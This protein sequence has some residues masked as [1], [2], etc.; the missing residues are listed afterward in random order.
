MRRRKI[1]SLPASVSK[2]QRPSFFTMGTGN[3]QKF[4]P[5]SSTHFVSDSWTSR[6]VALRAVVNALNSLVAWT[7]SGFCRSAAAGPKMARRASPL[8]A[9]VARTS[10]ETASS[11]VAKA[12]P[13]SAALVAMG[14]LRA[15]ATTRLPSLTTRKYLFSPAQSGTFP[16]SLHIRQRKG[17]GSGMDFI[18]DLL[19]RRPSAATATESAAAA[20]ERCGCRHWRTRGCYNCARSSRCSP[21]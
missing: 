1:S 12:L 8:C 11:G 17:F 9:V 21:R 7:R 10:A 6:L 16:W 14:R 4:V 20:T 13:V 19:L 15:S 2:N 18:G 3:G 5:T